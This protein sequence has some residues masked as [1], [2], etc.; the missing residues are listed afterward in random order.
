MKKENTL[1]ITM[2]SAVRTFAKNNSYLPSNMHDEKVVEYYE[3]KLFIDE[4]IDD[5]EE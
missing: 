4:L 5:L 3:L 2:L 1:A